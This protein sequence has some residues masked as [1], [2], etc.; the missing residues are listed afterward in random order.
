MRS[1]IC[2][3]GRASVDLL[4]KDPYSFSPKIERSFS[5]GLLKKRVTLDFKNPVP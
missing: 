4:T 2:R 5:K 3:V 1:G